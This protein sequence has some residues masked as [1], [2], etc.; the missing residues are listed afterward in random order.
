M[1]PSSSARRKNTARSSASQSARPRGE[2]SRN[3][4]PSS[5][6]TTRAS[7]SR[8]EAGS[9]VRA[10]LVVLVFAEPQDSEELPPRQLRGHP[11]GRDAAEDDLEQHAPGAGVEVGKRGHEDAIVTDR[12][13]GG[14]KAVPLSGS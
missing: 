8:K 5:E 13:G 14:D 9:G 11:D 4:S 7:G 6:Y 2:S 1:R 12:A 3:T 10:V